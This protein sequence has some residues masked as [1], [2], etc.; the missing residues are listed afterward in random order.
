MVAAPNDMVFCS[1]IPNLLELDALIFGWIVF[2]QSL[3]RR[4][5]SIVVTSFVGLKMN[6]PL[7][8]FLK[9]CQN[10]LKFGEAL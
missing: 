9:K 6:R 3:I 4:E 10:D 8:Y 1:F 2:W 7:N 5:K